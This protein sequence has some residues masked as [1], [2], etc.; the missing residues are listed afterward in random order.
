MLHCL[1]RFLLSFLMVVG[2]IVVRSPVAIAQ[3]QTL[4][5]SQVVRELESI[6]T[7]RSQ[8]SSHSKP[9]TEVCQVVAKHLEHL[10]CD[11]DWMVKQVS[12]KYRNPQNAPMGDRETLAL[13][14][15]DR[16]PELLGFWEGDRSAPSQGEERGIRYFQRITMS[17]SC[18]TCHGAKND[19]S[20]WIKNRYPRD[21]SYDFKEGDLAGMYSVWMA[22]PNSVIQDVIPDLHFCQSTGDQVAMPSLSQLFASNR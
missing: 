9:D 13:E 18:L 12:A 4:E 19:R 3:P 2:L 17:A 21:L 22:H 11:R 14:N 5:F 20:E 15:F 1:G 7:L 6:E 8:L 10:S 16:H